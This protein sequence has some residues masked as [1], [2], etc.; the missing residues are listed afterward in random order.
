[1]SKKVE[2]KKID[3]LLSKDELWIKNYGSNMWLQSR[4]KKVLVLFFVSFIWMMVILRFFEGWLGYFP[5]IFP[6][7][8]TFY[9][10]WRGMTRSGNKL[11]NEV[12]DKEQPVD[13]R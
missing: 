6:L 13:L 12:K 1:M 11:W 5:A 7:I 10:Y 2:R 8:V 4:G 9:M 3:L